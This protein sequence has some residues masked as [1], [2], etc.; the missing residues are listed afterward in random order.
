MNQRAFA[1]ARAYSS[2][3]LDDVPSTL[4]MPLAARAFGDAMF[5]RLAVG[6]AHA[7]PAFRKIDVDVSSSLRDKHSVF[8]VL[9]RTQIF[10]QLALD[11]LS[12]IHMPSPP[13]W[14]AD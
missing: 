11:F 12:T 9:L 8:G 13:I 2:V 7:E 4:F 1:P 10:K 14:A 6:D 3:Q 5:P